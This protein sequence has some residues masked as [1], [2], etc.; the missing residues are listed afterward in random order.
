M[1]GVEPDKVHA[2]EQ[3]LLGLPDATGV[4]DL[5]MR[6]LGQEL[7][8]DV[9]LDVLAGMTAEAVHELIHE[10]Q[11]LMVA[12]VPRLHRADVHASLT[13]QQAAGR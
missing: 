8:A 6:W 4:R 1:D 2:A 7:Q 9:T 12:T 11:R 10:A 13:A 5:R 3:V